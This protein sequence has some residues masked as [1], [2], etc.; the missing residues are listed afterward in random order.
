[1]YVRKFS[2]AYILVLGV[3]MLFELFMILRGAF[4]FDF[5]KQRQYLYFCSYLFLFLASLLAL[6]CT[7][8]NRSGKVS[9]KTITFVLHGYCTAIIFWSLLVSY[10][11]LTMGNT[12][13]V[14]FTVI[15]SVGGLS[16]INPIYY[17]ANLIVSFAALLSFSRIPTI[18]YFQGAPRGSYINLA[19]FAIVSLLMAIHNYLTSLRDMELTRHFEALSFRD[20]LTGLLNR[21]SFDEEI[22]RIAAGDEEVLVGMLDLDAFKTLNDTWGHDFGDECLRDVSAR[23]RETFGERSYRIGGDEFTVICAPTAQAALTA[24]VDAINRALEAAFPEKNVAIS[25]GFSRRG[26]A[27]DLDAV[28]DRADEALY[29]A[30]NGGKKRCCFAEDWTL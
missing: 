19:F 13:I 10:L 2:L 20:Q 30:K 14:Y 12:P 4:R 18:P 11:D 29:E 27:A 28:T 7:V 5:G 25:A 23:L 1:M 16:V 15:M 8:R 17:A 26:G 6:L 3:I 9:P 24:K 22:E 21:R